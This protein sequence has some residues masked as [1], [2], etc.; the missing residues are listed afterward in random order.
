MLRKTFLRQ[1]AEYNWSDVLKSIK[2][3]ITRIT[4]MNTKPKAV[5]GESC[6]CTLSVSDSELQENEVDEIS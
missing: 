6:I 2:K 5:M 1:V 3:S 4:T